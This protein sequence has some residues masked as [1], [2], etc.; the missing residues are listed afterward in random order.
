MEQ[1][2]QLAWS[3]RVAIINLICICNSNLSHDVAFLMGT[4]HA[5]ILPNIPECCFLDEYWDITVL[6]CFEECDFFFAHF[7]LSEH[8]ELAIT[9]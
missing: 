1:I 2:V 4:T 5:T 8:L 6:P 7:Q 3:C 9:Y